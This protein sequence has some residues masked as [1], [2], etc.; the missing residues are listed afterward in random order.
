MGILK[1]PSHPGRV[2]K[3]LYLSP[4]KMSEG[5]LAKHVGVPRTRIERLVKGDT[6]VTVDTAIRL[7]KAFGTTPDYWM[8]MQTNFDIA[9]SEDVAVER[10]EYA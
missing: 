2:L 7:S 4:L 9:N 6:G 5:K 8:N 3:N 1:K 10:L